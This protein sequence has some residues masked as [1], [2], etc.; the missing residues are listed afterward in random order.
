MAMAGFLE[1]QIAGIIY[2]LIKRTILVLPHGMSKKEQTTRRRTFLKRS[3]LIGGLGTFGSAGATAVASA[4]SIQV[5]PNSAAAFDSIQAGVDA[6]SPGDQVLVAEAEYTESVTIDT[7]EIII[8]GDP[9]GTEPGAGQAAPFLN[10]EKDP[11]QGF[12]I[13][14]GV[15]DVTIEGFDI[16][17]YGLNHETRGH[18][19]R[20]SGQ[21]ERITVR[22]N[23]IFDCGWVG[24]MTWSPGDYRHRE[25]AIYRNRMGG[26][27]LS[28][29]EL[30]NAVESTVHGNVFLDVTD[31][32]G[33]GDDYSQNGP[34]GHRTV[35]VKAAS[36]G[37]D[38]RVHSVDVKNNTVH[39]LTD[40]AGMSI[41]ALDGNQPEDVP[42]GTSVTLENVAIRD[43][44]LTG[45]DANIG[46]IFN[47]RP[48]GKG[49]NSIGSMD[50][51]GN[52]ISGFN[53]GL[54]LNDPEA[55][56][57]EDMD[58]TRNTLH[59]LDY[60][61][62]LTNGTPATAVTAAFND[63]TD[64][65][66]AAVVNDGIGVLE[67]TCNFWGHATGPSDDENPNGR[68]ADIVGE[69]DYRPWLPQSHERVSDN[70]CHGGENNGKNQD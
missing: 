52:E 28:E 69:I 19:I 57:F 17:N 64:Q 37:P 50:I 4:A 18:G 16:R 62:V 59:D 32:P 41:G 33:A 61:L 30:T 13:L 9:G 45:D 38:I 15:S 43:N 7:S 36:S 31:V 51:S 58:F 56:K 65:G 35:L 49:E 5:D 46:I 24:V 66:E 20:P 47:V 23:T 14:G 42:A 29:V 3:A 8:T 12:R 63:F 68:G 39:G 60:G 11:K 2:P 10:G 48:A 6:A 40:G 25:W 22:D 70:A 34:Y 26:S 53:Y 1:S 21:T 27:S 67:A 44:T 55:P 54:G